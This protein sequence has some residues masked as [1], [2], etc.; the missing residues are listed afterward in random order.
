[1]LIRPTVDLPP[2]SKLKP[3][4]AS[5]QPQRRGPAPDLAGDQPSY[6]S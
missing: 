3:P 1:M 2:D 5:R 4:A 6:S